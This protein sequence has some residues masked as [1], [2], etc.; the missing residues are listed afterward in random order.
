MFL[1]L[2]NP[3]IRVMDKKKIKQFQQR[4]TRDLVN[5]LASE[6]WYVKPTFP[7]WLA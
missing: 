6:M 4:R 5:E 3:S 2:A 7:M 1:P